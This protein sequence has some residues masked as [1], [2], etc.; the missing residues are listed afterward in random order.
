MK[1]IDEFL[2]YLSNLDVQLWLEGD[3]LCCDAPESVLTS[4]LSSQL[5]Q[6]KAE[7]I[8]FLARV[9][10]DSSARRTILPVARTE[11]LPLSFSQQRLW[12]IEQMM[13]NTPQYNIS[14]AIR[15]V[16]GLN[17]DALQE[18]FNEII[19]RHEVLRTNFRTFDGQPIQKIAPSLTLALP[20][21]DWR[22]LV[23]SERQA[24]LLR[25][26]NEEGMKPFNLAYDPLLRIT[27]I[28]LGENEYVV[29]LT[30][31]HIVSDAWSIGILIRE[32][33][34]LYAAFSQ[35]QPSPL[36]E[37]PIQYADF[38]TWQRQWLQ[39]EVLDRQLSYWKQQLQHHPPVLQL[40][41]DRPRSKIKTYQGA[42]RSFFVPREIAK[43][44]KL[45]SQKSEVTLFMTLLAAFKVLLYRYSSQADILVGS[46]IANRNHQ[47]TEALIGFFVNTL[48]LRTKLAR[49]LSFRDLLLQVKQVALDAYDHQDL[50]LEKLVEELNLDRDLS[51]D[52]LF[53]VMFV[54]QNTPEESLE[55]AD[56]TLSFVPQENTTAKFDLLLSM[57]DS[58]MEGTFEYNTDLFDE[59][60]IARMAEHFGSLLSGIVDRPEQ[61]ISQIPL[62][63]PRETQQILIEGNDTQTEYPHDLCFHHLFEAQV[64]QTPDAVAVVFQEQQLTYGELNQR[65]NQLAHYLQKQGVK[66]EFKVGLCVERSLSMIIGLLGILKAGGAYLPLDPTYPPERLSFMLSDSQVDILLTTHNLPELTKL[67]TQIIYLDRDHG[68]WE[69]DQSNPDSK[70]TIQN[71]AYLI[72]TSGSTGTP[73]GVLVSHEGLVN[74]TQDKIKT[75][76]VRGDSRILQFFSL[77]FDA[78]IPEIV[79]ALGSGAALY[80]GTL[81]D[82]LPGEPLTQFLHQNAITH[83]TLPPSALAVLPTTKLPDLQMVLVGGEAPSPELISQWSQGRIFI[84]AYGPTET[85]VNASMVECG[86]G[87]GLLPTVRPAANKQLYILDA[88]LQ[89]VAIGVPG[90]LHIAGVGLARGYLNRPQKTAET[91]IPN[92]FGD[93]LG[94]RLYKTGDLACYLSDGRIQLLGRLDHQVKVRGFRIEPGEIEAQLNQHPEVQESIVIVRED[95]VGDQQLVAYL[96]N[97]ERSLKISDLH[98]FIANKLPKYMIP[99][100]F[101]ILDRLPL[102]SN[103]KVD[104]FALP[105]PDAARSQL[106]VEFVAPRNSTEQVLSQIF[107]EVLEIDQV[108]VYDNFFELG[109]HSLL[110]TKLIS[111][112]LTRFDVEVSVID[113]FEDPTVEGLAK[114]IA[115]IKS[116]DLDV[117]NSDRQEL[118]LLRADAVLDDSI[119]PESSLT[120]LNTPPENIF[121]T[122]A[123]GFVGAFLL[124]ELLQQTSARIYCLV[125]ANTMELAQDKLEN[126]LKSY[127]L[128]QE[129]FKLK[130]IPVLGD[131][132][133]P[134]LGLSETKFQEF[135]SH[136]DVIYHNGAR[137]HHALPYGVLKDTNV[138]GTQE[139]LRLACQTKAKPIHFI[140]ASSVFSAREESGVTIIREADSIDR[141]GIP[142][143]GYNQSKW[144]AEKLVKA[145]GDRGLTVS[146]YRIG[147]IWGHS[148]TGVFNVNDYLY[149]L[150]IGCVELGSIPDVELIEN[151]IPVDYASQAII[152]LSQQQD[153]GG[154][155]FHLTHPESVSTNLFFAKLRSLGYQI[156]QITYE[157]WQEKLLDIAANSPEHPLYPLVPLLTANN[158]NS[159]PESKEAI[160]KFDCQNTLDGLQNTDLTCPAINDRLLDI[161]FSYLIE[162]GFLPPPP[163]QDRA[164]ISEEFITS[165]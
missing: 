135:S 129:T 1:T 67:Q 75:C 7:I 113:L 48:V 139:V 108:G 21:I 115:N 29:M 112:L 119:Q 26:A 60:T 4:S 148:Q 97:P 83:I 128:W 50:P 14:E 165:K 30:M 102:N 109:G 130:I 94:K 2:I 136:I 52:P 41:K 104:R 11:N 42:Q 127:L 153:S 71:L 126:C 138:I 35:G 49:N 162:H 18:S 124:Q 116:L 51:Y 40:P 62:L 69:Q 103:G 79:M 78:S 82:L 58:A 77:S 57:S 158:N 92:P 22:S 137:V 123:T 55:L 34:S 80:L 25:V 144:V 9:N 146:I 46:P 160:V 133:Q 147:R 145:A 120:Q 23:E 121:L 20:M 105:K 66:P 122:G 90:E 74:L 6:R 24:K 76:Q 91:F 151:I 15:L 96:V 152:H 101:V 132:S 142:S 149:R 86:N 163:L 39:G 99:S 107:A 3:R 159:D 87:K 150:I 81:T 161:S 85:T 10:S 44:L 8:A 164:Q 68:I 106:A 32:L 16:G 156:S 31:H 157:R 19:R 33:T 141:G 95:R 43:K 54:L 70:A 17:V 140:S 56:L 13:P 89:P 36:P 59:A 131:L 134:L 37:L 114:R 98:R 154:K 93:E 65:A 84:N 100:G 53:Q 64:E 117:S 61:S 45:L 28:R 38:A 118:V 5:T 47:E 88:N 155:A 125:R 27:L 73:K 12:F 72:Y 143:G 63:T 111:L 110:I